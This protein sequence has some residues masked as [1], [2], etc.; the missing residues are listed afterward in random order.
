METNLAEFYEH[1]DKGIGNSM[2]DLKLSVAGY[3]LGRQIRSGAI[4]TNREMAWWVMN[5]IVGY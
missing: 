3:S 4:Q 2:A 1:S 5:H